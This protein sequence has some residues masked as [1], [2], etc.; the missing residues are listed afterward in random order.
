M[1]LGDT[2]RTTVWGPL[3]CRTLHAL[4]AACSLSREKPTS[5][6]ASN[7]LGVSTEATGTTWSL[8]QAGALSRHPAARL[9]QV[10]RR[11]LQALRGP[12]PHL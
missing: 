3:S 7:W 9:Q 11:P 6:S 10:C 12:V 8:Q 4:S 1:A 2:G 5:T